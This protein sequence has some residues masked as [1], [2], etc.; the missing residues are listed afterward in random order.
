MEACAHTVVAGRQFR[1]SLIWQRSVSISCLIGITRKIRKV[2]KNTFRIA[3][4]VCHGSVRKG[5]ASGLQF[6]R[7]HFVGDVQ[8]ASESEM[9]RG[10]NKYDTPA[11]NEQGCSQCEIRAQ[12]RQ[13]YS[14]FE[15]WF[16]PNYWGQ[17]DKSR[18]Q[19][20]FCYTVEL[21]IYL[22]SRNP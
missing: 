4:L 16:S 7:W 3:R 18:L 1:E 21:D 20:I 17:I 9:R 8:N 6:E 11:P 10:A 14:L 19:K 22:S 12:K 15:C 13:K 2:R 5:T